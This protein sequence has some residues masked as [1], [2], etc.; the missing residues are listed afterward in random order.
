M[1]VFLSLGIVWVVKTILLGKLYQ[2]GSSHEVLLVLWVVVTET[3]LVARYEI[4]VLWH[5]ASQPFMSAGIL[6]I[7]YLLVVDES[8]AESLCRTILFDEFA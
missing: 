7:P 2:V 6:Q 1:L 3:A 8:D 4:L 5:T